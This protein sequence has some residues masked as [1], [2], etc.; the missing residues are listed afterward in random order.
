MVAI[1]RFKERKTAM[2]HLN[3]FVIILAAAALVAV[4]T[5]VLCV[6]RRRFKKRTQKESVCP[7]V[8]PQQDANESS[9]EIGCTFDE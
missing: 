7:P 9:A 5:V 8:L 2:P 3:V 6:L 4:L 1:V